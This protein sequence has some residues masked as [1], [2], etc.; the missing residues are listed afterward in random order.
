MQLSRIIVALCVFASPSLAAADVLDE[1]RVGVEGARAT[2]IVDAGDAVAIDVID[3]SRD[4]LAALLVAATGDTIAN[5]RGLIALASLDLHVAEE[6]GGV[7]VAVREVVVA[8]PIVVERRISRHRRR[9]TR[10]QEPQ[11]LPTSEVQVSRR[12]VAHEQRESDGLWLVPIENPRVTSRFGPRIDPVTGAEGRMHRGI[13][14][15]APT[16]TPVLSTSAGEVLLAGYCDGGTGNCVVID[17]GAGWRSQYFHL[18][19]VDVQ[20][21]ENVDAGEQIGAVGSTGRSTGP[22]LHFQIGLGAQA[23]DPDLLLGMPV[24]WAPATDGR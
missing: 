10:V 24:G 8:A 15:G 2:A 3:A 19:R 23:L 21:G 16:G 9:T 11:P 4:R 13:D 22:H 14:Y 7:D 18:S 6:H 5:L 17:H 12:Q 20:A 1:A